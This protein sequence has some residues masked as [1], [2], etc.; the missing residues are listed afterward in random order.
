MKNWLAQLTFAVVL[1]TAANSM[2]AQSIDED[3]INHLLDSIE[4]SFQWKTGSVP[5]GDGM[6][7][8]QVPAGWRYLP[9]DQSNFVLSDLWGNPPGASLGMLFPEKV[10]PLDSNTWAFDINFES[11]GYVKDGDA[12]D[13]DYK[14]ILKNL[15]K[16][17]EEVNPE[18]VK[19]GYD[20]VKIV[21]WA[22]EPYYDKQK[23]VLHWAKEIQ[24]GEDAAAPHT[25]NYDVRVLG[26]K[27]VLS[28]NAIGGMDRVQEVKSQVPAILSSVAF[29]EGHRYQDF[30]SN[31]DEVAAW[32][33]GGLVA[34]KV[35]AKAGFFAIILK[36]IKPILIALGL[37]GAAVWRF[38]TGRRK[39]EEFPNDGQSS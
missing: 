30:D 19:Q 24:F 7:T 1:C 14:D 16:E 15:Q 32:T 8:L 34:G 11:I 20:A 28:M 12:D 26:R 4:Q 35:L 9:S 37:G 10:S 18:R 39:Q 6:A 5:L 13:F 21:G 22:S 33:I 36:F 23:K 27:G 38:I 3:Y 25:L 17:A 2:S 31:I 29:N